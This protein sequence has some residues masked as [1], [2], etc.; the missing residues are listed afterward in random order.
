MERFKRH[1]HRLG[2]V[3][4][5]GVVGFAG[6]MLGSAYQAE[7]AQT[8]TTN[9]VGKRIVVASGTG[10]NGVLLLTIPG[11]GELRGF[12]GAGHVDTQINWENTT[13]G[14]VDA[15]LD[16]FVEGPGGRIVPAG[17]ALPVALF[18]SDR[19]EQSGTFVNLGQGN[20]P[21]PRRAA[22]VQ[23]NAYRSGPNAPCGLQAIATTWKST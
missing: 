21:G 15:W 13:T 17:G 19:G 6:G 16:Y 23:V 22:T 9:V 20:S 2:L 5:V 18:R 11:L 14:P 12:C 8:G 7:A 3:T 1:M 10:A 4:T